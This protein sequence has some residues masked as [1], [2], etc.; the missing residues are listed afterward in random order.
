MILLPYKTSD[1]I[2]GFLHVAAWIQFIE[3]NYIPVKI[4]YV[5]DLIQFLHY[6]ITCFQVD[7]PNGLDCMARSI[8]QNFL[9]SL[10]S[11]I[12][13]LYNKYDVDM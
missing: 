12:T 11:R 8:W 7:Y 10:E 1:S 3:W 5:F 4:R 6:P 9:Y 2:I 13:L